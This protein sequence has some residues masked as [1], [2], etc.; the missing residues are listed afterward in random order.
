MIP[1]GL[2]IV[3]DVIGIFPV[4]SRKDIGRAQLASAGSFLKH[5]EHSKVI[6]VSFDG[7][8]AEVIDSRTAI[9]PVEIALY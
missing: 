1:I 3:N 7:M 8:E 2:K 4:G 9:V 5:Y 6:F